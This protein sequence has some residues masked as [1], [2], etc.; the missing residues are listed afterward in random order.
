MAWRWTNDFRIVEALESEPQEV[1]DIVLDALDRIL[2]NPF[3]P[4]N[5]EVTMLRGPEA[6]A[7][8]R[9]AWLPRGF[10]LT[11]QPYFNGPPPLAGQH[12]SVVAMRKYNEFDGGPHAGSSG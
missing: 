7:E 9:I 5:V 6:R 1:R 8:R 12:V 4:E 2:E 11:Y 3:E 10:I